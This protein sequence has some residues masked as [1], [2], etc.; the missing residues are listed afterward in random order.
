MPKAP[1]KTKL[2]TVSFGVQDLARVWWVADREDLS[3]SRVCREAISLGL[4]ALLR[5][6]GIPDPPSFDTL[7]EAENYL[8]ERLIPLTGLSGSRDKGEGKE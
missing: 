5:K 8:R 7:E 3:F 4:P 2:A 1:K 6:K